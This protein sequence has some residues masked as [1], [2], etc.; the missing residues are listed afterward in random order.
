MA[1]GVDDGGTALGRLLF[2]R[3]TFALTNSSKEKQMADVITRR[4]AS[5]AVPATP[6]AVATRKY[7]VEA[8]GTF[9]LVFTVV[10]SGLSHSAFTPLAAGAVLMV[11]IY[12]GGHISC[13]DVAGVLRALIALK[14]IPRLARYGPPTA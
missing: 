13:K 7:T 2:R 3:S 5:R 14:L 12:A 4:A 1:A 9:F 8:I 11:M 6:W 10:V